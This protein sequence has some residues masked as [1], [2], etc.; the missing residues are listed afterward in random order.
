MDTLHVIFTM[1][2][3]RILAKS[4]PGG[5]E[6][7]EESRNSI[8]GFSRVLLE[9]ELRATLFIV[10]ETA[11]QHRHL[12][13]ELEQKGF[14]LGMH[15]HPHSFGDLR[16]TEY[17]GG[18]DTEQQRDLLSQGME[19]WTEA[20]GREPT[21]FRPGNFSANDA[22]FSVLAELGFRQGSVSAPGR[23][24]PNFRAVWAGA[25]PHPHHVHP[26]FKLV[27]GDL[28]FF[29]VPVSED[30]SRRMWKGRCAAE[31]R[32]ES[33]RPEEHRLTIDNCLSAMVA[34]DPPVKALVPMT[35]NMFGYEDPNGQHTQSLTEIADYLRGAAERNSLSM[36][37]TT[38]GKL[39]EDVDT[40]PAD[41]GS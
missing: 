20:L 3:E 23:V 5:P 2:C 14:E 9:R 4:P 25:H 28:D 22:T 36:A 13:L 31:L 34:D 33:A 32:V 26:E 1:D 21:T 40:R 41:S 11:Q 8:L 39:H 16:Y 30:L 19:L 17:L 38:I 18:Y 37:P 27:E 24:M 12:F 7:W 15:F 10:P 29:E 35:H 6:S